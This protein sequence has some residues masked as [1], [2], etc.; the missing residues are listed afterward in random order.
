MS[1]KKNGERTMGINLG[2]SK[3]RRKDLYHYQ[4]VAK[5]CEMPKKVLNVF[6]QILAPS[7]ILFV[8]GHR[9]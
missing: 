6:H 5:K 2:G 8:H 3:T 7:G 1:Y 4:K 9:C